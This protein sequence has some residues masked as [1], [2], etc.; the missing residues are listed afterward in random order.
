M[1]LEGES[2]VGASLG[3]GAGAG[4][5]VELALCCGDFSK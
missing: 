2:Y 3:A 5:G 1:F 4:A